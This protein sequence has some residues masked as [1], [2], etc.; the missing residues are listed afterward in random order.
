M[1]SFR[2]LAEL[3]SSRSERQLRPGAGIGCAA[4][5]LAFDPKPKFSK[6]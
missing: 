6:G 2:T 5:K 4:R 3:P 1:Q